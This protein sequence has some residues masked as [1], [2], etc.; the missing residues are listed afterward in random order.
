MARQW[1]ALIADVADYRA[2]FTTAYPIAKPDPTQSKDVEVCS[3]PEVWD[4][5]QALAGRAMDGGALLEYLLADPA[6]HAYDGV[7]G[8]RIRRPWRSRQSSAALHRMGGAISHACR[9]RP[10]TMP[11]CPI[12]S[13]INSRRRR[14]CRTAT[15]KVYVAND[16]SSGQARLVQP[17]PRFEHQDAG[18]RCRLRD[19]R[20]SARQAVHHHPHSRFVFGNAQHPLVDIRRSRD[21]FR[22]HRRQHH[23]SG[24]AALH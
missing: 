18:Q 17:R 21:Q 20:P 2:A 16:Y 11:G 23:R 22:R 12:T 10:Q 3:H 4:T 7:V 9:H 15:E 1:F 13:T 24:K 19:D 14:R 6:H 5:Y 8:H